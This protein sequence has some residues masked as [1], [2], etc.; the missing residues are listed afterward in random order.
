MNRNGGDSLLVRGKKYVN[1]RIYLMNL[2][3][4]LWE[5]FSLPFIE[6]NL[7]V[8]REMDC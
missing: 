3:A 8:E 5:F 7:D 6:M 2:S 1:E 4:F